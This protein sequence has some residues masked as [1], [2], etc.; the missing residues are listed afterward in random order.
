[1][2]MT[3]LS[4]LVAGVVL[5]LVGREALIRYLERR[6]KLV[7]E[8][9]E[10]KASDPLLADLDTVRPA[11]VYFGAEWCNP[12]KLVQ[13]PALQQLQTE[14]DVQVIRVDLDTNREAAQRWGVMSVP[15]TFVLAPGGDVHTTNLDAVHAPT[16]K[17]QVQ[18]T[19]G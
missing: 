7:A 18:A 2:L 10:I 1:M 17:A 6:I 5:I 11:V 12:C 15:R 3:I 8:Q 14:L 9:A 19:V 4:V 16:L 13:E